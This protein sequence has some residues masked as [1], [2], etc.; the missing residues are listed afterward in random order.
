MSFLKLSRITLIGIALMLFSACG[1]GRNLD[2]NMDSETYIKT[3]LE[4]S[5]EKLAKFMKKAN[6]KSGDKP[7]SVSFILEGK[8]LT[9]K[10]KW[11]EDLTEEEAD[12]KE[13]D[14]TYVTPTS[15]FASWQLIAN[16]GEDIVTDVFKEKLCAANV[17]LFAVTETK[18]GK[19]LADVPIPMDL[20][21]MNKHIEKGNL[22]DSR[23]GHSYETVQIGSQVWMAE[24]LNFK[25]ENSFCYNNND[26]KCN[27][28]GRLYTWDAAMSSCPSGWH[29]PTE[30]EWGSLFLSVGGWGLAGRILK[31][32][33][34]WD[35]YGNG[36]DTTGFNALPAGYM[37]NGMDGQVP[38]S[39]EGEMAWFWSSS[40]QETSK[41][42]IGMSFH[43]SNE[44]AQAQSL[45]HDDVA[46]YVRCVKDTD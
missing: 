25:T 35:D 12:K 18:D 23:D 31:S 2:P 41:W 14:A 37:P 26:Q 9:Y 15:I 16:A 29:L 36:S 21:C 42:K 13:M 44:K 7:A 11:L 1:T 4:I 32:R 20:F 34:G 19:V 43:F 5:N 46:L 45:T 39:F 17:K 10:V 3:V 22:Q 24:N 38:F 40:I 30:E 28:Y 33:K 6:K 27:V 8:R